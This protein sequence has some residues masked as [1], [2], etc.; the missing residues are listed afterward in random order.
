MN[1]TK[2]SRENSGAIDGYFVHID[3][4]KIQQHRRTS[5]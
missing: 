2:K 4:I 1:T 5:Q 3:S